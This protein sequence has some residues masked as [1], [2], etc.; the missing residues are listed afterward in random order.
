MVCSNLTFELNSFVVGWAWLAA[1]CSANHSVTPCPQQDRGTKCMEWLD[2]SFCRAAIRLIPFFIY[3][4][5]NCVWVFLQI[6]AIVWQIS[7]TQGHFVYNQF[8]VLDA[9]FQT[10]LQTLPGWPNQTHSIIVITI[11]NLQIFFSFF[12]T[13]YYKRDPFSL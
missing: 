13:I 7:S 4:P 10:E 9:L 1:M 2:K 12:W 5:Q 6:A 3:V 11:R 8:L